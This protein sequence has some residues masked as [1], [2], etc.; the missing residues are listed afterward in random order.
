MPSSRTGRLLLG[1][2]VLVGTVA[3]V[4]LLIGFE[5]ARLPPALLNIAAYKLTF[6]AALGLIAGGAVVT[7]HTRRN[8][9]G[10][11]PARLPANEMR[12]LTEGHPGANPLGEARQPERVRHTTP[13]EE[14]GR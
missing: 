3:S 9:T 11:A 4:G 6:L 5:P 13:H 1:L 12:E 10:D 14:G 2:G 7:R 8:S